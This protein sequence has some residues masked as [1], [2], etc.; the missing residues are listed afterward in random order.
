MENK[1]KKRK[2]S[3][4]STSILAGVLVCFVLIAVYGIVTQL[5][6]SYAFPSVLNE[7]D[8]D[9]ISE[10]TTATTD[11]VAGGAIHKS[12]TAFA[13][14]L[15]DK[16]VGETTVGDKTYKIDMFC[17]EM[18]KDIP[19]EGITYKK[20]ENKVELI[21][22]GINSIIISAYKNATVKDEGGK[23]VI[24][25]TA[26]EYY[27][28]QIAIWILQ[29]ESRFND[30]SLDEST[31]QLKQTWQTINSKK[32]QDGHSKII[33]NYV[34]N[35]KAAKES[36]AKNDIK[37]VGD[38]T[39]IEFKQTTD[40]KYY[41]TGFIKVTV[42]T[43]PNTEFSGF[44]FNL[45][46]DK[47]IPVK[48]IDENNNEIT[49]ASQIG[50]DTKFKLR[51]DKEALPVEETV[52]VTGDIK[53]VFKHMGFMSYQKYDKTTSK[54]DDTFQV[55]LLAVNKSDNNEVKLNLSVKVPDTGM[56]YSG[57]VY[58]IGALVLIVGMTIIYVNTKV[59]EN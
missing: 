43:A 35:A 37:V 54:Y 41:E 31:T 52:S 1:L 16:F 27:D 10:I 53:G 36:T 20:N 9:K 17:L 32:D 48:I 19:A 21:D 26:D 11:L 29:N 28:A 49:N 45:S 6:V 59:K 44:K 14:G 55:A 30:Q 24:S 46:N 7:I 38:D 40:E 2:D 22:E 4:T 50:T 8:A 57:Y 5:K 39:K 51:F 56:G 15:T 3:K 58:I 33:Y 13:R 23:K 12:D 34:T 47:N 42:T 18:L 25:L